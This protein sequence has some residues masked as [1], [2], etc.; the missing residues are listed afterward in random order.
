[1]GDIKTFEAKIRSFASTIDSM[2]M[3]KKGHQIMQLADNDKLDEAVYLWFTQKQSQDKPVSEPVLYEKAA[4][5]HKLLYEG[6]S[7]P[8]FQASRVANVIEYGSSLQGEKVSSDATMVEPSR[9]S[10]YR[11]CYNVRR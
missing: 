4:Q 11:N 1:M 6:K 2:G 10:G 8:P 5:L 3:S 7:V 9:N